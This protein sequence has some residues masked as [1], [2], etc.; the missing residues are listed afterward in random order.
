ML[1]KDFKEFV[2]LL[3]ANQVEYLVVG[4]YALMVHGHPRY[5]GDIDFWVKP[6]EHNI[7]KLLRALNEF[8]F[9][10]VGLTAA[11][12]LKPEAV[13]QLGYPPARI[14]LM[15]SITGVEFAAAYTARLAVLIDGVSLAVIN[16]AD[17]IRNKLAAGRF[18]DLGDV[19]ALS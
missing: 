2:E 8:G 18:K 1:N 10:S 9:A 6:T 16:R 13:I 11:D 14:D 7:F 4:G 12:F 17:F 15:A 19:E 3:N 5:T